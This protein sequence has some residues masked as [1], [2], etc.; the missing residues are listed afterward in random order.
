V[1]GM[2][3][4]DRIMST[5]FDVIYVAEA[6][7]LREDE[8]EK[9]A[10][11]LRHNVVPYQQLLA[12]CNPHAPTH[13]L[14]QRC[15]GGACKMW[16][17]RHE[18]NPTLFDEEAGEYT[19]DGIEYLHRLD[20]LTGVRKERL[21]YGRWVTAEGVVY[22]EWD[23]RKHLVDRFDIPPGWRRIRAIDFGYT[24]PFVCLWIACD[25]D[26]RAFVYRYLY[27]S[28]ALVED[29][30]RRIVQLTEARESIEATICDHD[31]E[32]NATLRRHGVPTTNAVKP[33]ASGIEAVQSRLR[34]AG[35]GQPRLFVLRDSLVDA[36]LSLCETKRPYMLEQEF[37][38]YSWPKTVD[39]KPV[40]ELPVDC[41][42]H[43]LDALR[44]GVMYLDGGVRRSPTI[45]VP[46]R[47]SR[48]DMLRRV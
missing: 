18:D 8:W 1:G 45:K 9:L 14:K 2:D 30:A 22:D 13:W 12:D 42:N 39:G 21:R 23:A 34:D 24:N 10:T 27:R 31:A 16:E 3:N 20:S 46:H 35:D 40:K 11:R 48:R 47:A 4:A 44:Y 6:T 32:G 33:I 38:T 29:M 37:D 26:G 5:E 19:A 41:D 43:A 25:P 17:S 7:E 28:Q 36:D 15:D